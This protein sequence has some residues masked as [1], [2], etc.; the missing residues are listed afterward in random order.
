M[1]I[2]LLPAEA[3]AISRY[4]STSM[5]CDAIQAAI[6]RERAVILRFRSPRNPSLQLY[7]RYV[8][9]WRQCNTGETTEFAYVPSADVRSCPVLKCVVVDLDD[10]FILRHNR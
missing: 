10:E 1:L 3:L 5:S 8:R 2:A 7:N 6:A 4:T 9:D